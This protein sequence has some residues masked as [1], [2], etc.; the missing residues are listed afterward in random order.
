MDKL[1]YWKKISFKKHEFNLRFNPNKNIFF[2]KNNFLFTC[3]SVIL[4]F[5]KNKWDGEKHW[6]TI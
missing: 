4:L 1:F 6:N 2:E 5:E 3:A